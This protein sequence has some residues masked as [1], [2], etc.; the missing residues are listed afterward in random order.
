MSESND[1][2]PTPVL[3]F[4]DELQSSGLH[5]ATIVRA[6]TQDFFRRGFVPEVDDATAT[7]PFER[8]TYAVTADFAI[9]RA[10]HRSANATAMPSPRPINARRFAVG[11]PNSAGRCN[12]MRA[13]SDRTARRLRHCTGPRPVSAQATRSWHRT[14]P[15]SP[16]PRRWR[17]PATTR[18]STDRPSS[19]VRVSSAERAAPSCRCPPSQSARPDPE[20]PSRSLLAANRRPRLSWGCDRHC[21]PRRRQRDA[22]RTR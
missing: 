9:T 13:R 22:H 6:K 20:I 10:D 8:K 12:P 11:R 5:C 4:A 19:A 17:D 16:A 21:R 14:Q 15:C 3:T 7:I 18:P 2:S 1:T